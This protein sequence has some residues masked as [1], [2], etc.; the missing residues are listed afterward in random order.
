MKTT[1]DR[2]MRV[3]AGHAAFAVILLTLGIQGL[4]KGDFTT[5]WQPVPKGVPGREVPVDLCAALS[6]ASG[7]GL[8]WR[9]TAALAAR[10]LLVSLLLWLLLWRVR[11]LRDRRTGAWLAAMACRLGVF[12][13]QHLPRGGRGDSVRCLRAAGSSSLGVA[14][15]PVRAAGLASPPGGRQGRH[16]LPMGRNRDHSGVDG[17]WLGGGGFLPRYAASAWHDSS[18]DATW[19]SISD[20]QIDGQRHLG[21]ARM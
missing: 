10:V 17:L 19:I 15:G 13:R 2:A 9:R 1:G 20:V 12:H 3:S 16:R 14:N 7:I 8:L 4:I 6:L 18:W 11:A 21:S 5:V